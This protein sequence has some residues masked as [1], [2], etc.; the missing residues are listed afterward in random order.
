[1]GH[2]PNLC[3]D[4]NHNEHNLTCHS[5]KPTAGAT[6]LCTQ[7]EHLKQIT[8]LARAAQAAQ[9]QTAQT[10]CPQSAYL[11]PELMAGGPSHS[12]GASALHE[13]L[14]HAQGSCHSSVRD[15]SAVREICCVQ[16][17]GTESNH[18]LRKYG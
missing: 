9:Q 14:L 3:V 8:R 1:M 12:T 10:A 7:Q 17:C 18:I 2:T 15:R 11:I 4:L 6:Q 16:S 13:S 5:L